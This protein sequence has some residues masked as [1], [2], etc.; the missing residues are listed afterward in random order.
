MLLA[1]SY[2]RGDIDIEGDFFSAIKLKN[3]ILID[4]SWRDK[5]IV[6]LK[7]IRLPR[8]HHKQ[9]GDSRDFI[10]NQSLMCVFQ[11]KL[12]GQSTA[13]WTLIPEQTGH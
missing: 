9:F 12:D 10:S 11:T 1:E 13:N 5:L 4:I 2:F 8:Y 6:I 3:L 7:T